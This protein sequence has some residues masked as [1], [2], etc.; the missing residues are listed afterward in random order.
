M[1]C[2]LLIC[3]IFLSRQ[4]ATVSVWMNSEEAEQKGNVIVLDPGHGG[5]DPG[6]IGI[7]GT[8]RKRNQPVSEPSSQG[9]TGRKKVIQ[10]F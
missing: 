4:A 2:F 6:M 1:A 10:L 9:K 8:G 3:F 5:S 7:D